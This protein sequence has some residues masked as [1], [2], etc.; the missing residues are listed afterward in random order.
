MSNLRC[1]LG[2]GRIDPDGVWEHHGLGP[3][4]YEAI[5][6]RSASSVEGLL[7]PRQYLLGAAEVRIGGR[8]HGDTCGPHK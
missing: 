7:A 6:M 2:C 1:C 5:R 8:Q 4:V 3:A